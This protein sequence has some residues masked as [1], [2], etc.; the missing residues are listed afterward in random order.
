MHWARRAASRAACTAGSSRAISTAMI[1]IT[2]S[3]SIRVKPRLRIRMISRFVLAGERGALTAHSS[4]TEAD[5]RE[6]RQEYR[7]PAERRR[8]RN[9]SRNISR[10]IVIGRRPCE[11]GPTRRSFTATGRGAMVSAGHQ[12][13][14]G[15]QADLTCGPGMSSS[16]RRGRSGPRCLCGRRP[17]SSPRQAASSPGRRNRRLQQARRREILSITS[18]EN[19]SRSSHFARLVEGRPMRSAAMKRYGHP[20]CRNN[21]ASREDLVSARS[22]RRH[23]LSPGPWRRRSRSRAWATP[24]G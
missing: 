3:N 18:Y 2:T 6:I 20:S 24:A 7:F 11:S 19:S 22:R 14:S 15:W 5:R 21:G 16:F 9:D 12:E 17:I 13:P 8:L 10:T 1:A 23:S 4:A